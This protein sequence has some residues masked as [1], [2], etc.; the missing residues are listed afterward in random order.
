[1]RQ[2]NEHIKY[3]ST[4]ERTLEDGATFVLTTWFT[5]HQ[6]APV[7]ASAACKQMMSDMDKTALD[8][9]KVTFAINHRLWFGLACAH[10]VCDSLSF[11]NGNEINVFIKHYTSAAWRITFS[12]FR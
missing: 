4:Q 10:D 6:C 1:M 12:V 9:V 8:L 7:C 5:R 3:S 11:M 2:R